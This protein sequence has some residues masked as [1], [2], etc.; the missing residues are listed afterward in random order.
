MS[1]YSVVAANGSKSFGTFDR[2]GPARKLHAEL[3]KKQTVNLIC[4]HTC[5]C[6]YR[7]I[8]K[9]RT[10]RP[11]QWGHKFGPFEMAPTHTG[12]RRAEACEEHKRSAPS[13]KGVRPT[14]S[15]R[16]RWGVPR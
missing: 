14:R 16:L 13:R 11:A 15:W 1:D 7:A 8:V 9:G 4:L 6:V 12:W 10:L 2:Y 5:G 3:S